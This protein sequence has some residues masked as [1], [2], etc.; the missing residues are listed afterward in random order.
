MY[1]EPIQ[2]LI[3]LFA[4]F[5]TIGPRTASR[6]VFYL[7]SK[8]K[9]DVQKLLE[10]ITELKEKIRTCLFCF[11]PFDKTIEH[12]ETLCGV[13]KNQARANGL[14]CVVEKESDLEA[15]EKTQ[16]YDGL[17][18]ILGGT[19]GTLK[20]EDRENIRMKELKERVANPKSFGLPSS[21]REVIIA[22]N[23]TT[24]GEATALYLE[25]EL[26][27][28]GVKLTRLGRGL[29]IGAELEYA[30]EETLRQSLANRR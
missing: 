13:C 7:L 22:L 5:P 6:F 27:D 2:A 20:K 9:E 8:P 29:P 17:Y 15:I 25:R 14:L 23:P 10:G 4:K 24:E 12:E 21:F 16:Q 11:N 28:A 30:D 18:F 3:A 26:K 1:P 19:I